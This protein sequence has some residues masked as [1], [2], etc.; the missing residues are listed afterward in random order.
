MQPSEKSGLY[1]KNQPES[2]MRRNIC[3]QI[4]NTPSIRDIKPLFIMVNFTD[5]FHA[6]ISMVSSNTSFFIPVIIRIEKEI[7]QINHKIPIFPRPDAS[8][9]RFKIKLPI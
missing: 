3:C 9:G 7:F 2:G 8:L 5:S 6:N 1:V 4:Q